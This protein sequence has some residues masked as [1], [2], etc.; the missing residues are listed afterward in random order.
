MLVR[1]DIYV[2]FKT[3]ARWIVTKNRDISWCS[4]FYICY[5]CF[6]RSFDTGRAFLKHDSICSLFFPLFFP[7]FSLSLLSSSYLTK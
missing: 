7:Y 6:G 1:T 5:L 2:S 3:S 4:Y